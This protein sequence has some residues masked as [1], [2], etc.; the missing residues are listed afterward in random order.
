LTLANCSVASPTQSPAT[1]LE[2]TVPS[3]CYWR[4][5]SDSIE[6]T[7]TGRVCSAGLAK[8]F[9]R[10][11]LQAGLGTYPITWHLLHQTKRST[12]AHNWLRVSQLL[13]QCEGVRVHNHGKSSRSECPS[14]TRNMTRTTNKP[15][16]CTDPT[17]QETKQPAV[18]Q[19]CT[20]KALEEPKVAA[21]NWQ[22]QVHTT[23]HLGRCRKLEDDALAFSALNRLQFYRATRQVFLLQGIGRH[24]PRFDYLGAARRPTKRWSVRPRLNELEG[25]LVDEQAG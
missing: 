18:C 13:S 5:K 25:R 14:C 21:T 2:I 17:V 4:F 19:S 20:S 10:T 24:S 11:D 15:H 16:L 7:T 3:L 6:C 1:I 12:I 8:H 22:A 23:H 9:G